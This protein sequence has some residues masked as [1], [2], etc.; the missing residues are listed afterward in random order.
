MV[1]PP[2]LDYSWNLRQLMAD[3]YLWKIAQ[4]VPLLRDRGIGLSSSQIRRLVTGKPERL[5]LP[6][7]AAL[8]DI[9][10]CTPGD[11][12]TVRVAA[13]PGPGTG[14]PGGGPAPRPQQD[15]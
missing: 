5:S 7:L 10:G 14:S 15:P 6:V 1:T 4:L 8:C 2:R 9:L 13:A 12:I 3:R 11:L